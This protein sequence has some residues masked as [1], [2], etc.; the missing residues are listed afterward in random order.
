MKNPNFTCAGPNP[1]RFLTPDKPTKAIDFLEGLK[2]FCENDH[3]Y[4][5]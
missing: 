5:F 4:Y 1:L 2:P 3:I